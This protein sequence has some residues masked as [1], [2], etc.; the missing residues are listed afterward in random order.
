M[1]RT[2][3]LVLVCAFA[4]LACSQSKDDILRKAES[5]DTKEA[6]REALGSPDDVSKLGPIE[7]WTYEASDGQVEYLITGDNVRLGS[8]KDKDEDDDEK[9]ED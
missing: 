7:T 1:R 9:G 5:A 4:L 3:T 2:L 6:L 8:T